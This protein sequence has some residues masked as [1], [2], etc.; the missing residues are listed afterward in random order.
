[1]DKKI[2]IFIAIIV[3]MVVGLFVFFAFQQNNNSPKY[4]AFAQCLKTK[5]VLFYGAFWCPHCQ[6]QKALFG[7][8]VQYLPY[9]ECSTPDGTGQLAVCTDKKIDEYP[10]WVF[11]DGSTSEGDL[12]LQQLADKSGC[13]LPQ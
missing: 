13:T 8:A 3:V 1:M 9:V 7:A 6:A 11:P 2:I 10:T 4:D 12:T 5:G